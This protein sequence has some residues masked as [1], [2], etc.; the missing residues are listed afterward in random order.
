MRNQQGC[1]RLVVN[2]GVRSTDAK[3]W[4][5]HVN[6][7]EER[8]AVATWLSVLREVEFS[9]QERIGAGVAAEDGSTGIKGTRDASVEVVYLDNLELSR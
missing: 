9:D 5:G 1:G 3:K 2:E 8:R 4:P 7:E 6:S